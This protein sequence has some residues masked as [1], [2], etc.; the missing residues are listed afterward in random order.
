M[1][2]INQKI[3]ILILSLFL[4]NCG[5]PLPVYTSVQKGILA[6]NQEGNKSFYYGD[7]DDALSHFNEALKLAL[8]VENF[9]SI[10]ISQINIAMVYRKMGEKTKASQCIDTIIS[11]TNNTYSKSNIYSAELLKIMLLMDDND[12][13]NATSLSYKALSH[14]N[15]IKCNSSGTI[16]NILT[17]ISLFNKDGQS[18]LSNAAIALKSNMKNEEKNETANS[19]RLQGDAYMLNNDF[20]K[21]IES[22]KQ[23][24]TI[25]KTLDI[26][27]KIFND[28]MGIGNGFYNQGKHSDAL[29]FFERAHTVSI[30]SNVTKEIE[31]SNSMIEKCKASL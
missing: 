15:E 28:L 23:A 25:D 6:N 30:N 17:R 9:N 27:E 20:I 21:A 12:Y 5:S 26:T 19:Y 10:A 1:N 2:N 13:L 16:Y 8:S 11:S 22:Y 7:Y 29:Q 31:D 18:A 3:I 24:L 4:L 14:C